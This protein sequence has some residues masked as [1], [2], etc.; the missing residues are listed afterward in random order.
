MTTVRRV[1]LA[2]AAMLVLLV[3]AA[4]VA[5]GIDSSGGSRGVP[6]FGAGASGTVKATGTVDARSLPRVNQQRQPMART[7]LPSPELLL[8]RAGVTPSGQR[9]PRDGVRGTSL[10]VKSPPSSNAA[11]RTSA[12]EPHPNAFGTNMELLN[13]FTGATLNNTGCC[14]PPDTQVAVS[15]SDV[16]EPVNL[17]AFLFDHGGNDLGSF[18]LVSFFSF[19]QPNNFG[20]D[21]KVAYDA[22]TDRWY[23]TLMICQN[24]G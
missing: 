21:P 1:G 5:A 12:K 7:D 11:P 20:S 4:S 15:S 17:T 14:E 9:G 18:D 6:A 24:A 19:G 23:M 16:F 22:G 2:A 8:Q 10:Q 13:S 3:P